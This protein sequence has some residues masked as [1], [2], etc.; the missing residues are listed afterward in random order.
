MKLDIPFFE[1]KLHIEDYMDWEGAVESFFDYMAIPEET[2]V[3]Y[4]AC[5]LRGG[6]NA[7]WQQML[8]SRQRTGRGKIR[9]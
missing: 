5:R 1:G 4:V 9:T 2:Q 3:K 8:Q 7:W 6:A